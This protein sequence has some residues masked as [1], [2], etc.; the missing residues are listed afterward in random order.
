[1]TRD[2]IATL[3]TRHQDAFLRRDADALTGQHAENGT[4]ESPA[5]GTVV[6]RGAINDLYRYWFTAFPDLKLTWQLPIIDGDRAA[7]FWSFAGTAHGPFFGIVG[8]GTRV[9]MKG[10]SEYVFENGLIRSVRTVYDFSGVLLK[11][12]VLKVKSSN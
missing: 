1:M 11:A 8:A 4:Y 2:E 9:E 12:G 10:A 5:H 6:G 3:L 7:V